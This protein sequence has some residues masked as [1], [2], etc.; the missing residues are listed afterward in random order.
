VT[1]DLCFG[2]S[3]FSNN[4]FFKHLQHPITS[5]DAP[6]YFVESTI[7]TGQVFFVTVLLQL[8]FYFLRMLVLVAGQCSAQRFAITTV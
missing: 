7:A 1:K 8:L 4:R 5:P 3:R 2:L 6:Q